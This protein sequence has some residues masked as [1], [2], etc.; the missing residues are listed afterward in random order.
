MAKNKKGIENITEPESVKDSENASENVVVQSDPISAL[1]REE[2]RKYRKTLRSLRRSEWLEE[3]WIIMILSLVVLALMIVLTIGKAVHDKIEQ[4]KLEEEQQEKED[5]LE[6]LE[7]YNIR[8][9]ME[10]LL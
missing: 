6:Q 4:K 1:S 10:L 2:R 3:Y 7:I 8:E 9:Q 5:S